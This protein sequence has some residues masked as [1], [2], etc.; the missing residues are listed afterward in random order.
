MMFACLKSHASSAIGALFVISLTISGCA[1]V[2]E[3]LPTTAPN[4]FGDTPPLGAIL[5]DGSQASGPIFIDGSLVWDPGFVPQDSGVVITYDASVNPVI[6]DASLGQLDATVDTVDATLSVPVPTG[7][8]L[9]DPNGSVNPALP[10]A[11]TN[12]P[13]CPS[14][15]PPDPQGP[16]NSLFAECKYGPTG[17]EYTCPCGL[18]GAWECK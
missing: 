4:Y 8:A 2:E 16:C 14:Y 1:N 6:V 11:S 12:D 5:A 18:F 9:L 3:E 10:P 17:S 7:D 15:A 13:S